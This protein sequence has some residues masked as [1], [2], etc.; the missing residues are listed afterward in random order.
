M[1]RNGVEEEGGYMSIRVDMCRYVSICVDT[2]RY[3]PVFTMHV[4]IRVDRASVHIL[5]NLYFVTPKINSCSLESSNK[6][7]D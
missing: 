7:F 3:A 6:L 1:C 4:S 5:Y 2:C